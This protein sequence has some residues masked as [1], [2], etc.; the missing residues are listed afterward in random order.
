MSVKKAVKQGAAASSSTKKAAKDV[1]TAKKVSKESKKIVAE[2]EKEDKNVSDTEFNTTTEVYNS[3]E[4]VS[5]TKR[6]RPL[7]DVSPLHTLAPISLHN[8][9][10]Y[11]IVILIVPF[12]GRGSRR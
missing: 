10:T 5:G 12:S 8:I 3:E 7:E 9:V 4:G 1:L 11:F 6:S 2:V